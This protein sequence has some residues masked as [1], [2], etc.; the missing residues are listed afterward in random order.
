MVHN[1]SISRRVFY[2][3]SSNFPISTFLLKN[4]TNITL[5]R[6]GVLSDNGKQLLNDYAN[7]DHCGPC[8]LQNNV[9]RDS[10]L[11]KQKYISD[12]IKYYNNKRQYVDKKDASTK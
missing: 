5:G 4:K 7:E 9:T 12:T 1:Y 2:Y 6:W 10:I 8:G 3:I 11:K